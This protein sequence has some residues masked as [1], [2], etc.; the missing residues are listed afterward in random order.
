MV[1]SPFYRPGLWSSIFV[2]E[3]EGEARKGMKFSWW[4]RTGEWRVVSFKFFSRISTSG[5][6]R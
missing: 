6:F 1:K 2:K 5:L 4:M 3:S